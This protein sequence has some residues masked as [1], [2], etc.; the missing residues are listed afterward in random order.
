VDVL[1][2]RVREGLKN[3]NARGAIFYEDVKMLAACYDQLRKKHDELEKTHRKASESI[4][5]LLG[6]LRAAGVK[7]GKQ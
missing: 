1:T 3:G 6:E 7:V 2:E 4:D 5:N